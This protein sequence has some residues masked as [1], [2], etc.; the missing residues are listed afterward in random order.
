M[1]DINVTTYGFVVA[2][3]RDNDDDAWS[4]LDGLDSNELAQVALGATL[5]LATALRGYCGAEHT[6]DIIRT[7]Q[8]FALADSTGGTR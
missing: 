7:L 3:L 6:D 4:L 2:A 1:T 8:G 5:A